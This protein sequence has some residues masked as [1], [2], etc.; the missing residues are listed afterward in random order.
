MA[1]KKPNLSESDIYQVM[2]MIQMQYDGAPNKDNW[3]SVLCPFHADK[4][5]GNAFINMSSAHIYCFACQEEDHI[6]E[7]VRRFKGFRFFSEAIDFVRDMLN[8]PPEEKNLT[9]GRPEVRKRRRPPEE[10]KVEEKVEVVWPE[11]RLDLVPSEY[12]YTQARGFTP[13]FIKE[14]GI[15]YTENSFYDRY[16]IVPV[17]QPELGIEGFEARRVKEVEVMA[18]FMDSSVDDPDLKQ[19][20]KEFCNQSN[21]QW[22][23]VQ[24]DG[25]SYKTVFVSGVP[26]PKDHP[27]F[28]DLFYLI[29]PK[30]L[31]SKN[32]KLSHTLFNLQNLDLNE[33]LYVVEGIGGLPKVWT[34]LSKN[35]TSAFGS[36]MTGAQINLLKLFSKVVVIPDDDEAGFNMVDKLRKE[37]PNLWVRPVGMDDSR[38]RYT[39]KLLNTEEIEGARWVLR[40]K[41]VIQNG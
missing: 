22:K 26:L 7:A 12:I 10:P 23:S 19:K 16:M 31:Y 24:K 25:K 14:F 5:F 40:K 3:L 15:Y 13:E 20:F 36:K 28:R 4:N 32:S 21:V 37:V 17:V 33:P 34:H 30:V 29:R 11:P 2:G 39:M 1:S 18:S 6:I 27:D 9:S 38:P 35:V 41:G 8:L